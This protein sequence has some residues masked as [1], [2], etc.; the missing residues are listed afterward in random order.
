MMLTKDAEDLSYENSRT[1]LIVVTLSMLCFC[2]MEI[3]LYFLYLYKVR[4]PHTF[5]PENYNMFM[6]FV[7]FHPW[8]KILADDKSEE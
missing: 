2:I 7:Q 8:A 4:W 6:L 5:Y 3:A 1:C